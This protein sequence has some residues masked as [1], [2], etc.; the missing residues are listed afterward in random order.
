MFSALLIFFF[1]LFV[2]WCVFWGSKVSFLWARGQRVTLNLFRRCYQGHLHGV[3][4]SRRA[5]AWSQIV[6]LA[7]TMESTCSHWKY[8]PTAEKCAQL[9]LL[10]INKKLFTVVSDNELLAGVVA[11]FF[12]YLQILLLQQKQWIKIV[13]TSHVRNHKGH[14]PKTNK[15][16]EINIYLVSLPWLSKHEKN[17]L[18]TFT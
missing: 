8:F 4:V 12:E 3:C 15:L 13:L 17:L 6:K 1:L 11:C 7:F 5:K 16:T 14:I 2:W 9:S 18:K 10:K